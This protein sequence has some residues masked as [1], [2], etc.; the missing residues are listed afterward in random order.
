MQDK[1]N[2]LLKDRI[3]MIY[4]RNRNNFNSNNILN[5]TSTNSTPQNS[6]LRQNIWTFLNQNTLQQTNLYPLTIIH[7]PP[8]PLKYR[9]H[10]DSTLR[11]VK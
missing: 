9:V 11:I 2:L 4:N 3:S 5:L 6:P 10:K 8:P 7:P 1:T